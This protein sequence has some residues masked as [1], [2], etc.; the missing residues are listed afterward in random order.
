MAAT[1]S[2]RQT[3]FPT[4]VSARAAAAEAAGAGRKQGRILQEGSSS[5]PAQREKTDLKPVKGTRD[6]PPRDLRQR[7]WLFSHFRAV[8]SLFGFEEWD[9]PVL[10]A[11][12]LYTRKAGEEISEQL[13]NFED[14]GGR[15]VALRPEL[16][17]SLARVALKQ[18]K[19][20]ALPAKW[21]AVGQC[22]RYERMTRGRRREH[23][24]W[25]LDVLGAPG[26]AAEAELLAAVV[27]LFQ[28]LGLTSVDVG[29]K[30]SHRGV[31][32]EVA[33]RA[34]VPSERF[35]A[36]CVIIDKADKMPR[37]DV[38]RLLCEALEVGEGVGEGDSAA[39]DVE[40]QADALLAVLDTGK[41]AASV[42]ALLGTDSEAAGSLE[43]LFGLADAYGISDWLVLDTGVVRGLAYYTG[44]VFEGFDRRGELRAVCGGGRYDGLMET[45]GSPVRVPA[46]GFGFGD[47]VIIELLIE[48]GLLPDFER[49]AG[50]GEGLV[51]DV[52][53]ALDDST[54][55][56]AARAAAQLRA[57]GRRVDLVLEPK[58]MQWVFKQCERQ[59]AGR[60]ITVGK[61]EAEAGTVAVRDLATRETVE[62]PARHLA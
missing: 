22:W 14:R 10:E 11:E 49:D 33:N 36:A 51:D 39:G 26:E 60:L 6:F 1:S 50:D 9:A 17:P 12:A 23:Y 43:R 28:R 45:Y 41:D 24:Q 3:R 47:A 19:A 55:A 29:L 35:G 61:R 13:Y 42:R 5:P 25:N 58:K 38:R 4:N 21:S 48:R 7:A 18:G 57:Q 46:C 40:A 62:V 44:F 52:V 53:A 2:S 15:R 16:T 20:L 37:E 32:A 30:V 31:L 54:Q 8:S 27:A 34:G 59:G 56:E